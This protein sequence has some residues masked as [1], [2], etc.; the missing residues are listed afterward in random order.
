MHN[1]VIHKLSDRVEKEHSQ[2]LRDSQR[3]EDRSAVID[4]SGNPLPAFGGSVD[5]ESLVQGSGASTTSTTNGMGTFADPASAPTSVPATANGSKSTSWEDDVWGSI[6]DARTDVCLHYPDEFDIGL[7]KIVS[8]STS[9]YPCC[10]SSF[11]AVPP[12]GS[13]AS[14]TSKGDATF[15]FQTSRYPRVNIIGLYGRYRFP[16]ASSPTSEQLVP[17]STILIIFLLDVQHTFSA[18]KRSLTRWDT[19]VRVQFVRR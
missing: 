10:Y 2:Y 5:F 15:T 8:V 3:N 19:D 11:F 4:P 1:S 14:G 17:S 16:S 6:L 12:R 7:I 13:A 9:L 18:S